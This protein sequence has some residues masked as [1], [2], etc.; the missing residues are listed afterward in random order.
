MGSGKKKFGFS[1]FAESER[2][3][4]QTE[5][6]EVRREPQKLRIGIPK[7]GRLQENRVALV[8]SSVNTITSAGHFI[9]LERGAGVK[10]NF[11]DRD[12]AEAGAMLVDS[13][14]EVF[15][16]QVL[17]KVEP[18]S[19]DEA[20]LMQPSQLLIS[21]LSIPIINK[22]YINTLLEKRVI[23][24]AMEYLMDSDGTFP[25][26]RIMSEMAGISAILTAAEL[27]SNSS[28]GDGVLLG[29]ISGVP[30]AKVVILGAGVVGE[31][32]TR[33]ALGLGASVCIFDNNIYKLMRIQ[34]RVGR[35]LFT[36]SL[37]PIYLE[38]EILNADVVI[39]AIHS[40]TGR[41]P[42]VVSEDMVM[43]MKDGAVV[44]DVSID[45]GGCIETSS[46]TT[47]S[48]PT[49]KKHGVVHYCVPNIA[50][51]VARTASLAVS[52]I[53]TPILLNAGSTE[54]IESLFFTDYGLRHGMYT[55]KGCLT[56][57]YLAERFNLKYTDPD[58][59]VTSNL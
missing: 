10:A 15:K 26:V 1:Y 54:N 56:N 53:L 28:G 17:I 6:L 22:E 55:F 12:Y 33:T 8:P 32:A 49:F 13:K 39:G 14:E 42:I 29:G 52:N 50:S 24:V 31:F 9:L 25:L 51:R 27:L 41:S 34:Q 7:E 19:N 20:A 59:L 5:M 36:S 35:Q 21:P 46:M 43:K 58:L 44:I 37:N 47:H 30:P 18:P 48:N 38:Q 23:A 45:Q 2:Y 40:E 11:S 16:A 57:R 3:A 4:P